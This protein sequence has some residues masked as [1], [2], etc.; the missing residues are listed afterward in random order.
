MQHHDWPGNIRQ[1]ENLIRS[2]ILIGDEEFLVAELVP[3]ASSRLTTE[4]DL[5]HPVSLKEITRAA[6]QDLERQIVLKVLQANGYSRLK[7]AKWLNISY[8]S[9]LYKLQDPKVGGFPARVQRGKS[10][11]RPYK[12]PHAAISASGTRDARVAKAPD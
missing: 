3:S 8:R 12:L 9:L 11:A 5:A 10:G 2:Y 1:L 7:T 6:T 4:I